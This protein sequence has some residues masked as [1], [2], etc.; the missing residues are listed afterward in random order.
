VLD[1]LEGWAYDVLP[2]LDTEGIAGHWLDSVPSAVTVWK[3]LQV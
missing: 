2:E 1:I 3:S